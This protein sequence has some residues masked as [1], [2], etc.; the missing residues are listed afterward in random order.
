MEEKNADQFT[1]AVRQYDKISRLEPWYTAI[2]I[3]IKR[4]CEVDEEDMEDLR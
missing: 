2:L 4:H 3:R 1:E